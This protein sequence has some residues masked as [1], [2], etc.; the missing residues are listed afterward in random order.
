[1]TRRWLIGI[2]MA[3]A[4][5]L[6]ARGDIDLYWQASSGFYQSNGST[7]LLENVGMAALVQLIQAGPDGLPDPVNMN[8][9]DFVGGDDVL[10]A[11]LIYTNTASDGFSEYAAVQFGRVQSAY[12]SYSFYGR[13]FQDASPMTGECYFDGVVTQTVDVTF[14]D[15]QLYDFN[16]G[17]SRDIVETVITSVPEPSAL[18]LACLGLTALAIR[19]MRRA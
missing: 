18:A 13:I 9:P 6:A 2:A 7:P 3:A 15:A 5:G 10:I 19:A 4:A 12:S 14:P 17:G 16:D 11:Q 1:M 8:E